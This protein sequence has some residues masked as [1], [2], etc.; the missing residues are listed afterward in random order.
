MTIFK[1]LTLAAAALFFTTSLAFAAITV[2]AAKQQGLVGEQTDGLLGAVTATPSADVSALV[3][4]TNAA[5][6]EKYNAIAAKNGTPVDQIQAVAGQ[7]LIGNTPAG[8]YI[9]TAAGG[10]QKK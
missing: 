4:S 1:K 9:Q 3:S 6:M 8:E 10:W 2:D 7:K 5:R